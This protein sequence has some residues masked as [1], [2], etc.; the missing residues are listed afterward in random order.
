MN[1]DK[2]NTLKNLSPERPYW[3][4][5][6]LCTYIVLFQTDWQRL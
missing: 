3:D 2:N 6:K 1:M 5:L 4:G